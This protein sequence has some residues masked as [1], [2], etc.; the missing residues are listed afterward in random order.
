MNP[1]DD[2]SRPVFRSGVLDERRFSSGK[3]RPADRGRPARRKP[4]RRVCA[5]ALLSGLAIAALSGCAGYKL[6]PTNGLAAGEQSVQ[7]TP[8]LNK[9]IEPRLT[10][11]VTAQLHEAVQQDGTYKLA[12]HGDGD[13]VVTGEITRLDRQDVTFVPTDV[14][15]VR[16]YRLVLTAHV[17]ARNRTTGKILFDQPVNGSTLMRVGNDITS[18]ERQALPLLAADLA[19]NVTS[20]LADGT[21]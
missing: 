20:L 13:I 5:V 1:P 7:I 14:L 21:W 8:F 17:T 19:R 9:T 6:G 18:A 12:T 15:T 10:D 3:N 16:D 4:L 11:A 2:Q